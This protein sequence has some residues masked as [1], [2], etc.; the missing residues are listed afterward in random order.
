MDKLAD[1][2]AEMDYVRPC[3]FCAGDGSYPQIYTVGCG[4]GTYR[5]NGNCSHC[6]GLGIVKADGSR[7]PDSVIAQIKTKMRKDI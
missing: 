2:I 5:M 6:N 3:Y 4:G 7:P 1:Y